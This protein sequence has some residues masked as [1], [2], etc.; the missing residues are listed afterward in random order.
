M[1]PG[2]IQQID[3]EAIS[4]TVASLMKDA[5]HKATGVDHDSM[6]LHASHTHD[7][8]YLV[9]KR[10]PGMDNVSSSQGDGVPEKASEIDVLYVKMAISRAADAAVNAIADLKD[11]KL[12]IGRS[13]AKR[14]SFG[15]RYL[16]KDGK[17][18]TNPG[19]RNP[20]IVKPYGPPPDEEVQVLRVDVEGGKPI[21]IINFL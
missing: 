9:M 15:R 13:E 12:S 18:R 1:S 11:A 5:I 16:M 14:I 4:D 6:I 20:D 19:I 17:V 10:V 3:T 7:G 8:G 21:C 2:I